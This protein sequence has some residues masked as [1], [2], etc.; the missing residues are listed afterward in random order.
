[1]KLQKD[2]NELFSTEADEETLD[3]SVFDDFVDDEDEPTTGAENRK[4]RRST[5][6]EPQSLTFGARQSRQ[7]SKVLT[8]TQLPGLTSVDQMHLLALAD[9]VS[10]IGTRLD[11]RDTDTTQAHLHDGTPGM[12]FSLLI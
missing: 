2:Y 11:Q 4:R 7:L 5:S 1:L 6:G 10:S 8:R 3:E 12:I 9:T